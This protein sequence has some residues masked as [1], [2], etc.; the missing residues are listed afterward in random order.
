ME[1]DRVIN[2]GWVS[3]ERGHAR[4]PEGKKIAWH[5][6]AAEGQYP[7]VSRIK[8]CE[9]DDVSRADAKHARRKEQVGIPAALREHHFGAK[10]MS[11]SRQTGS[12]RK[13][14]SATAPARATSRSVCN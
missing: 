4:R 2:R 10:P 14:E 3:G 6:F 7:L 13:P 1:V 11:G 5:R 9:A 8:L 12:R